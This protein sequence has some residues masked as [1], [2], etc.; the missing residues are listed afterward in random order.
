M[1]SLRPPWQANS[2]HCRFN[3]TEAAAPAPNGVSSGSAIAPDL[4]TEVSTDS[5][6]QAPAKAVAPAEPTVF[7]ANLPWEVNDEHIEAEFKKFGEIA[8]IKIHRSKDSEK[9]MY[10]NSIGCLPV[11]IL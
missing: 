9:A 10:V 3:S 1:L 8:R 2:L 11:T 7:I 4:S 6:E 5:S